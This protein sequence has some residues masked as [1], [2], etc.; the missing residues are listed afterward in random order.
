MLS[1]SREFYRVV[2]IKLLSSSLLSVFQPVSEV[3]YG[4]SSTSRVFRT[5]SRNILILCSGFRIMEE[6]EYYQPSALKGRKY[7]RSNLK[8]PSL[9]FSL[10]KGKQN[11]VG[12]QEQKRSVK[13][14]S[15]HLKQSLSSDSTPR[16]LIGFL[17]TAGYYSRPLLGLLIR[18][19]EDFDHF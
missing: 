11:A 16:R 19:S 14:A 8:A 7:N 15:K 6:E 4:T 3:V 13:Q 5:V 12:R 10:T 17:T 2:A 9:S 1:S 18:I